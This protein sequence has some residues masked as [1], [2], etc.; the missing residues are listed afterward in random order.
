MSGHK[1][2]RGVCVECFED[3]PCEVARLRAEKEA[4]VAALKEAADR[5][6]SDGC[7]EHFHDGRDENRNCPYIAIIDRARRAIERATGEGT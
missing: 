1:D 2:E 4:L 7:P 5:M 3:W 6:E